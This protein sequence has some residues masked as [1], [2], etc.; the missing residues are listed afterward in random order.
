ML[1][2]FFPQFVPNS[3]TDGLD[4]WSIDNP[5]ALQSDEILVNVH[6]TI[7]I[8]QYALALAVACFRTEY[9]QIMRKLFKT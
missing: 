7:G 5:Q 2:S 8:C 3:T 6:R 1:I 9:T 4:K